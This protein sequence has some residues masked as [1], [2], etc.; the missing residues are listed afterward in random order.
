MNLGWLEISLTFIGGAI[1]CLVFI[2]KLEKFIAKI[3]RFLGFLNRVYVK[4][5]LQIK[6]NDYLKK[7]SKKVKHLDLKK[8]KIKWVNAKNQTEK[9]YI[10]DGKMIIRLQ[11]GDHQNENI[12][13]ASM[14]FISYAFL[15]KAKLHIAK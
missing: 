5:D 10:Q 15:K 7:V 6:I 2:E 4:R 13:R 14:A 11:Q 3:Y 8:I 1:T 9:E 12:V